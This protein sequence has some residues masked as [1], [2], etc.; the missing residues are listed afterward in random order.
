MENDG[1]TEEDNL[2]RV[3]REDFPEKLGFAWGINEVIEQAM[4]F[5]IVKC[6]VNILFS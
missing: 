6:Y 3:D 5:R 4:A 2:N 1:E